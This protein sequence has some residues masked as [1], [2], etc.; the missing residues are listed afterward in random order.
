MNAVPVRPVVSL[1]RALALRTAIFALAFLWPL[2]LFGR[3]AYIPDSVGYLKGGQEAFQFLV[4]Q[5]DLVATVTASD[6][7]V[8]VASAEDGKGAPK[9][10]RSITYSVAA[11]VLRWPG[12]DMTALALFQAL[13]AAFV[14]A[15][16]VAALNVTRLKDVVPVSAALSLATPVAV[17][18]N[19]AEP[20]IFAGLVVAVS[21][22]FIAAFDRLA[23]G[24]RFA[25][26][27]LI[28]LSVAVHASIPPLALGMALVGIGWGVVRKGQ[29][30][31]FRIDRT[32]W[33]VVPIA[34]SMLGIATMNKV[35]FGTSDLAGKRYPLALARSISDGPGRWYL[36]RACVKPRYAVC[37]VFGTRIPDTVSG[38]VFADTGLNGRAN[39]EQMDRIRAEEAEIVRNAALAYPAAELRN[40]A[41][42]LARQVFSLGFQ[43]VQFNERVAIG[44]F[45]LPEL[46]PDER[47]SKPLLD[48]LER[49]SL[50]ALL[51]C[52]VLVV[53]RWRRIAY[54]ARLAL[55]LLVPALLGNAFIV[56]VFSGIAQRYGARV[57][58]LVPLFALCAILGG[59]RKQA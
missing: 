28:A 58:W 14:C 26:A 27:L 43:G 3:P 40:F 36:E 2:V 32:L 1:D 29:R 57:I 17:Y 34:I 51:A 25:L 31:G 11:Y 55:S 50:A 19:A 45:A 46:V 35:A 39:A 8:A 56:V 30:D 4:S 6:G 7:G 18:V 15:V 42:H 16:A 5:Q 47:G 23:T 37:E 38:F 59:T 53:V 9:A 22:L 54:D 13:L 44:A 52:I 49:V 10:S 41:D 24:I 20:D 12:L 33:M 48:V 21:I